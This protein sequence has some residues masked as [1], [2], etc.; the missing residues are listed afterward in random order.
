MPGR[1]GIPSVTEILDALGLGWHGWRVG[2]EVQ[3]LALARGRAVHR[4][5]ELLG[6]GYELPPLHALIAGPVD[7]YRAWARDTQHAVC[8]SEQERVH[9]TRLFL[10][11][12]DRVG[13]VGGRLALVDFK[14]GSPDLEA[15]ALQLAGYRLLIEPVELALVVTLRPDGT[16]RQ[17]DVTVASLAATHVFTAATVVFHAQRRRAG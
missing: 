10:G 13:T 15:A 14:T 3:A 4:S 2:Q 17:H 11:H 7:A 8:W 9:P 5:V 1:D 16:Y 12:P 6:A